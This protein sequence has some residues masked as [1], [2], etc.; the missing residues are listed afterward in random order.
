MLAHRQ[1]GSTAMQVTRLG[2]GSMGIRGP[3]TWG[4][5]VVDEAGAERILH[6]VL[7]AG[8]NF[9][10]TAPDYGLSEARIGRYLAGRRSE[11]FLATKCGCDYVQRADE[12]EIR[13]TWTAEVIRRN[14]ETSLQRLNTNTID[15]LQFHGGDA[16]TLQQQGLLDVVRDYQAQG[17]VRYLGV[18]SS[19][20]QLPELIA[21]GGFD[22]FQI[23][24]SC[25]APEHEAWIRRA[26]ASGAGI[27]IRGG[28]AQGGPD[29]VI[30]RPALTAI[31]EQAELDSVLSDPRLPPD[32][33][34][35][36]F[37]L[38]YTLA[39]P[40]I[41]TVIVGTADPH[42]LAENVAAAAAGPLPEELHAEVTARVSRV[43]AANANERGGN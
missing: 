13:H 30:Q 25:L 6:Q 33:S 19:L 37:I 15:L 5:R 18:S 42:H 4:V 3:R 21:M 20:P 28:V 26:A 35:A 11:Y 23:P 8:I 32:T 16:Q 40:D 22:V 39:H 29:A 24:Y 43:L 17:T 14:V 27:V 41:D 9:I 34:R 12:L 36:Q 38:R 7:D 1:L 10:D 2:Y 31:W